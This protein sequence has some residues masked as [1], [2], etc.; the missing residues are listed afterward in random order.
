[1]KYRHGRRLTATRCA[2]PPRTR[3]TVSSDQAFSTIN[4][5]TWLS[6]CATKTGASLSNPTR[7]CRFSFLT[8]A[9]FRHASLRNRRRVLR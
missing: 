8:S 9:P 6:P 2:S 1:V 4:S 7:A 5:P 3:S